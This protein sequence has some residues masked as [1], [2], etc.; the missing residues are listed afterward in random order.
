[1]GF[2]INVIFLFVS[3]ITLA[4]ASGF[5]AS[6]SS[7]VTGLSGYSTNNKLKSAHKYLT[8]AAVVGFITV[9]FLL[10]G[11]GLSIFFAP[12]A[13]EAGAV[14]GASPKNYI[15]YGLLFLCLIAVF[16]V[17]ILA[18]IAAT[19]INESGVQNNNLSYRN[20]IIAA[21]LSI[22]VSVLIIIALII[23]VA[24][25]PKKKIEPIDKDIAEMK[26]ELGEEPTEVKHEVSNL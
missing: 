11:A 26:M 15:V 7:K 5:A 9:F 22:V 8:I 16:V 1:M 17:G 25:K 20:S 18:A 3:F 19:E 6:A 14:T 21:V 23:R 2:A 12:E 10:V 4:I 24:Y 13:A